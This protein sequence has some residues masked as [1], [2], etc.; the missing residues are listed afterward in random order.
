MEQ[1]KKA[2]V[3]K[4]LQLLEKAIR[5]KANIIIFPEY[6]CF[7]EMQEK[8]GEY[9]EIGRASCRERVWTYV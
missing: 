2:A 1:Q 8:I 3:I 7:P 4:A 9:L 5:L 6:V